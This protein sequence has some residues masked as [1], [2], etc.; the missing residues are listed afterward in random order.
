MLTKKD[1]SIYY[2]L[3]VLSIIFTICDLA[4]TC[5][6]LLVASLI[7][8]SIT[9]IIGFIGKH[10]AKALNVEKG[11]DETIDFIKHNFNCSNT[12]LSIL[13]VLCCILALFTG[14]FIIA[15]ISR[16]AIALRFVIIVN[17]YRTVAFGIWSFA[18]IY[19]MKRSNHNKMEEKNENKISFFK[20]IAIAVKTFV[21]WIWANKKSLC[22]TIFAVFSG[23][24]SA[25]VANADLIAELPQIPLFNFNLT[26][27]IVGVLVFAGVEVG[28]IGKGF[29]TIKTFNERIALKKNEKAVAKSLKLELK[30]E[31]EAEKQLAK[32]KADALALEK[33]IQAEKE[34]EKEKSDR[35]IYLLKL[36]EKIHADEE[37]RAKIEA[38]KAEILEAQKQ[39]NTQ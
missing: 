24:V 37:Y 3:I 25:I 15:V 29:E 34:A 7:F 18:F 33:K 12:I 14:I 21:K 13:D 9:M 35:E 36:A 20:K 28:V 22:G 2:V 17:K 30:A 32:D 16:S 27:I 10:K 5:S 6:Q 1:L 19:L 11:V 26:A 23:V 4:V 38:E 31:K 8:S 39:D